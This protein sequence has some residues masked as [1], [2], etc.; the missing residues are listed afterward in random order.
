MVIPVLAREPRERT[1][2]TMTSQWSNKLG[3]SYPEFYTHM[4]LVLE[5]DEIRVLTLERGSGTSKPIC[6]LEKCLLQ[7]RPPEVDDRGR[8]AATQKDPEFTALSYRWKEE[9]AEAITCNGVDFFVPR[10]VLAALVDIRSTSACRRLWID[11][12]C[13]NQNDDQEKRHQIPR[14]GE[15]YSRATCTIIWLGRSNFLSWCGFRAWNSEAN[16]MR[17]S[18]QGNDPGVRVRGLIITVW[19]HSI[20]IPL[21]QREYFSRMWIIQEV[22][23]SRHLE[24]VCGDDR[25]TMSDFILGSMGTLASDTGRQHLSTIVNIL[26]CRSLLPWAPQHGFEDAAHLLSRLASK[27]GDTL[28]DKN[29][30]TLLNLFRSSDATDPVDKIFGLV[31]LSKK[32]NAEGTW[33]VDQLYPIRPAGNG[34]DVGQPTARTSFDVVGL[35]KHLY[36]KRNL[37]EFARLIRHRVRDHRVERTL[38]SV[39]RRIVERQR[40]LQLLGSVCHRDNVDA[41]LWN[42]PSWVPDWTDTR[43]VPR[44]LTTATAP[45]DNLEVAAL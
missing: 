13:I 4:G 19:N 3:P 37:D 16:D 45:T 32:I 26:R 39:A 5:R 31:G 20:I 15:I 7:A 43:S 11:A 22:A 21:L 9:D 12:I 23:L 44:P 35:L 40:S 34:F 17:A 24:F 27:K 14:M 36:W 30:L 41:S 18:L 25:V 28:V 6:R 42:L 29:L 33:D 8:R 2:D 10:N 38:V 1:G